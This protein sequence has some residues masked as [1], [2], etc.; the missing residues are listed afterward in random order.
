MD[1]DIEKNWTQYEF[2]YLWMWEMTW[3]LNLK[4]LRTRVGN[5]EK[6]V[7]KHPTLTLIR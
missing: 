3:F 2:I 7:D 4:S 1:I 6:K 5:Y